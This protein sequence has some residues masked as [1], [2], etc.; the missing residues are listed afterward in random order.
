MGTFN[1]VALCLFGVGGA[2][3]CEFQEYLAKANE[4]SAQ[5]AKDHGVVRG[6][7]CVGELPGNTV[8]S[9]RADIL[10]KELKVIKERILELQF[11]ELWAC[12][13][14]GHLQAFFICQN[15]SDATKYKKKDYYLKFNKARI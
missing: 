9:Y 15:S 5:I 11:G 7:V 12:I 4:L 3:L 10:L 6:F 8:L 14:Y 1:D 13:V 2:K